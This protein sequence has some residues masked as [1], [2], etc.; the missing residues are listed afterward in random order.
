[1]ENEDYKLTQED[2]DSLCYFWT[3]KSDLTRWSGW[4]RAQ[5]ALR[6]QFPEILAAWENYIVGGRTLTAVL[7]HAQLRE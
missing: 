1:M 6:R 3:H 7:K 4:E 5:P 2:L